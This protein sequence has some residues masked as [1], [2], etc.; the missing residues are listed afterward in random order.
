MTDVFNFSGIGR[1]GALAVFFFVSGYF[2]NNNP[3]LF[4]WILFICIVLFIVM[5]IIDFVQRKKALDIAEHE[6]K[7][8]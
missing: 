8:R 6:V 2:Y 4:G 3:L 7:Y 5:I 1:Y